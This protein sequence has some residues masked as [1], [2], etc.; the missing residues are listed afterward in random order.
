[1]SSGMQVGQNEKT[2]SSCLSKVRIVP[3]V[4][5][6]PNTTSKDDFLLVI[7]NK[8][9]SR[10]RL[11]MLPFV[12]EELFSPL[13]ARCVGEVMWWTQYSSFTDSLHEISGE[14][15]NSCR[16]PQASVVVIGTVCDS[17]MLRMWYPCFNN[18]ASQ[19]VKFDHLCMGMFC[20]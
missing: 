20:S 3:C 16:V 14:F 18:G 12:P 4:T 17:L 10:W 5:G 8:E 6:T 19:C 7:F 15:Q 1:M 11:F 13:G 9:T 2:R